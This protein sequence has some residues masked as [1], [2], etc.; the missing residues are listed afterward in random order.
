MGIVSG[1]WGG[2]V[3]ETTD[4]VADEGSCDSDKVFGTAGEGT[5]VGF[6]GGD[7]TG[8]VFFGEETATETFDGDDTWDETTGVDTV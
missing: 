4:F 6:L 2:G 7:D 8:T 5:V 3:I 1:T